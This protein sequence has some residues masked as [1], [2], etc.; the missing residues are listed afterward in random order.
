MPRTDVRDQPGSTG[1][2]HAGAAFLRKLEVRSALSDE[3]RAVLIAMPVDA[4]RFGPGQPIVREG[5]RVTRSCVLLDGFVCRDKSL[6]DGARQILSFHGAGDL[7]G[8]HS[9]TLEISDDNIVAMTQTRVA[10]LPHEAVL[11][12]MH[13]HAGIARAFWRETLVDGAIA[14]E[15][16]LNIG[17]RDAYARLAHLYCE[18]ALRMRAV[19]L[20]RDDCF[21][22]P[23]TQA[24]L[25]DAMSLTPVHVNRTLQRLRADGLLA[26]RGTE[27]CIMDWPGL[28]EA[29]TFDPAYLYLPA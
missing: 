8:L 22:F 18:M 15:W 5:E 29:G 28:V 12:A 7:I 10:Y 16:L 24:D 20:Y 4:A 17:R 19:G 1:D 25:A 27:V 11:D 13:R 23:V 21:Q 3:E 14:R 26:T 6:A 9:A 2:S